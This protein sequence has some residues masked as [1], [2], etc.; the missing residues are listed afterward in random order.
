MNKVLIM[1]KV[2]NKYEII[3]FLI[4]NNIY[5]NYISTNNN[6]HLIKIN[7]NDYK[8]IKKRFKIKIINYYGKERIIKFFKKNYLFLISFLWGLIL[9]YFLSNTIFE[10]E[11]KTNNESL[12]EILMNELESYNIKKYSGIK[13]YNQIKKI[14][15]EIINNNTDK[16]EWLEIKRKGTKYEVLLTERIIIKKEEKN[17]IPRH[18]VAS[19]DALIK[20]L[21]SS[22]GDVIKEVNDY[23]KKGEVIISGNI[24]KYDKLVSS[25]HAEGKVYGEVWYVV[26]TKV[27]FKYIE[28]IRTGNIINHYYIEIFNK[29]MTLFGK[30]KAAHSMNNKKILIDKPYLFFKLVKESKEIYEYKEFS[31]SSE[32]AKEEAIKR[33]DKSIK[34]KLKKNEYIIDKKVLNIHPYSSKIELEIFY[35]VYEDITDTLL[36]EG[37]SG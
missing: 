17:T 12:K 10:I 2:K 4:K 26:K 18:I 22:S 32:E 1:V 30:Y 3:N 27:P 8:F 15:N 14:K 23:V 29:K 20:H 16:I 13:S 35:K 36:I 28:Y 33:S 24:Y 9:L 7:L 25:V 5:F 21:V 31:I 37:E 34:N 6:K 11:I 19:K